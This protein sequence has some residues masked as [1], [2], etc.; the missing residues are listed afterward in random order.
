M[1]GSR[2][3]LLSRTQKQHLLRPSALVLPGPKARSRCRDLHRSRPQ[4]LYYAVQVFR[5]PH[6]RGLALFL[7]SPAPSSTDLRGL[8]VRG[9][10]LSGNSE[11]LSADE[12][13]QISLFA[14]LVTPR[15]AKRFPAASPKPSVSPRFSFSMTFNPMPRMGPMIHGARFG[16]LAEEV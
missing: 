14:D 4:L 3:S 8:D 5:E 16:D 9:A 6:L 13:F 10:D 2:W 7:G 15:D 11:G 12:G 1:P